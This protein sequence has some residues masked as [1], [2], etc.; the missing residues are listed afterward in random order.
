[1]P[2]GVLSVR[3]AQCK[4]ALIHDVVDD[5]RLDVLALTETWIPSGALY[6]V[7]LDACPPGY[8]VL[9]RHRGTSNQRGGG[10]ALVYRDTIKASMVDVG[11]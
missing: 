1:M 11:N 9:H 6:A 10:M 4:A 8:K 2:F 3:S 5:H 7:K